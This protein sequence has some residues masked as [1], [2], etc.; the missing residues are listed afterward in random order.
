MWDTCKMRHSCAS[1]W[2]R[3]SIRICDGRMALSSVW[4][5][6]MEY[7][8]K[9]RSLCMLK[10]GNDV[11]YLSQPTWYCSYLIHSICCSIY[12]ACWNVLE[13]R[14]VVDCEPLE[15]LTRSSLVEVCWVFTYLHIFHLRIE[16]FKCWVALYCFSIKN[17]TWLNNVL[18][19]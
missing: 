16:L 7:D 6:I 4:R 14:L 1:R 8:D 10:L 15:P 18:P 13:W 11:V 12:S 2:E 19:L 5:W 3:D 9:C 17:W